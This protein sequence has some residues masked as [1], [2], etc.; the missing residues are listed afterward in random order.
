VVPDLVT[1]AKGIAGGL[2]LAGVTGRAELM[3]AVHV[4]GLG[5]TYGGNP[6]ACAAAL[7]SIAEM[8]EH[9]LDARALELGHQIRGRLE[10]LAAEHPVIADIRGRGAM[11]AI[12]LCTPGTTEPDAARAA[13]VNAF[14]HKSGV[15]TLTCGTWGNVFRFLPPLAIGDALLDEAFDVVA[16]AF[17]ATA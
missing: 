10:K 2:P 8:K 7:G 14:C 17:A 9:S 15:V 16:E 4:G 13:A 1:T 5:G 12:E 6:V 3:D 11:Q